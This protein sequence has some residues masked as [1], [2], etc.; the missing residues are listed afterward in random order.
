VARAWRK[1]SWMTVL[2]VVLWACANDSA[3]LAKSGGKEIVFF[4]AVPMPISFFIFGVKKSYHTP[5]PNS[6]VILISNDNVK[7][8]QIQES[9]DEKKMVGG[10]P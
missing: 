9:P 6:W 10:D 1:A 2:T 4:T 8:L 5:G 7:F 3:S